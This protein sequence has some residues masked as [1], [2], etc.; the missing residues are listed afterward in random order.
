MR[1][2]ESQLRKIVRQEILRENV[3][4][5]PVQS[6]KGMGAGRPTYGHTQIGTSFAPEGMSDEE[7]VKFLQDSFRGAPM[8]RFDI[9]RDPDTQ[10]IFAYY[11][12]D[13]SG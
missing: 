5:I 9:Y 4:E 6:P 11:E 8:W 13:T 2:T 3:K 7:A 12:I 1:I 10:Q